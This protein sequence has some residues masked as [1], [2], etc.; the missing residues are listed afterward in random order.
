MRQRGRPTVG[1]APSFALV[2]ALAACGPSAAPDAAGTVAA[3][4]SVATPADASDGPSAVPIGPGPSAPAPTEDVAPGGGDGA[5]DGTSEGAPDGTPAAPGASGPVPPEGELAVHFLDVGQGDAALLLHEDARILIDTGDHRGSEVVTALRRLG[6]DRL[7]LV[8]VSHPHADHLG[9]FDRVLAAV[10]VD[11][12]WWSGSVTTTRT[13]ERAIDALE[14]STA[15]YEEPRAGDR[16]R[17]GPVEV[18]VLH[19][20][21]GGS[22]RDLHDAML[23]VRVT[24]GDVRFLFTGDAEAAVE[25]RLLADPAGVRADVLKVGH[26]GSRTS[27]TRAFLDAV[28]PSIAVYSA[29]AGNRYGHPHDEVVA[30]IEAAGIELLGTD[31]VGT[32]VVSTDGRAIT[33]RTQR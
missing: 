21:P 16:A 14:S 9:Q 2:L 25:A 20:R 15:A 13:F 6:V 3:D 23:V 11:E 30:R 27:T 1:M 31:R 22:L 32:V 12:V 26:H 28:S 17:F 18:E 5:L 4:A 19:P 7:D 10:A 29:G 33:V 8:I 24:H